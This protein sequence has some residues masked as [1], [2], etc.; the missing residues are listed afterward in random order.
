MNQEIMETL[1]LDDNK[2]A[3][4]KLETEI[5][6]AAGEDD[7][8]IEVVDDTPPEDRGREPM[9]TPPEEPTD[10]E[11]ETYSKR[12]RNRIREFTKG[13]HDE[14]RAKEAAMR[15]KEQAVRLAQA[16][17]EEN[18][19]LKGSVNTSQNA[20]L[21]QAKKQI[22][23]ELEDAKRK[24]KQAYEA[25]D[26]DALV[27][28]QDLLTSVKV[29][30]DRLDNIRPAP[31]EEPKDN[32]ILT[33]PEPE[34]VDAKAEKW[35]EQNTWWGKDKEM[36]AFALAVHDRLVN[37]LYV[38]PQSDEYYRRLNARLRQVF[39]DKFES[40][41]PADAPTQ[42]PTKSNV[43]ASATRSV[44]P[45]KITLSPSEVN[46]AKRLGVSLEQYA[47]EVARLRRTQNG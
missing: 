40:D 33:Q 23:L 5:V 35:K 36:T 6:E 10:E 28:A 24:Y 38:D 14:R 44:A 34:A 1:D 25:G 32:F 15:E 45:K 8:E 13:Y 46:I 47:R 30:A 27:E 17:F 9:K 31:T 22:A 11:L 18:Q 42:R 39:P 26:S 43:V 21:E 7:F 20:L 3:G 2:Q 29:K 19:K 37:D 41:E 12:D 16:Y 4:D